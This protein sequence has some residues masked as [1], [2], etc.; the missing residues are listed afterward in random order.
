MVRKL[1]LFTFALILSFSTALAQTQDQKEKS[2][3]FAVV[4]DLQGDTL[5]G[6]LRFQQEEIL[7][8]SEDNKEKVLPSK[9][10]KSITLAKI[11][12]EGPAAVDPNQQP[13]YSVRVE[14][15]Q[16]IY[17]LKK[18]YTFS[19]NTNA[20]LITKTIDPEMITGLLST[21]ASR[22]QAKNPDKDKPF[23][24]DKSIVFS[25]EFKF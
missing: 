13:K 19:L 23:I 4:K 25:L 2:D 11:K 1:F 15:S 10:I 7:V 6:Y 22:A 8:A 18:K 14:N 12:E 9:Y 5:E 21:D 20:G 16:E 24:Q 17:T 3:I